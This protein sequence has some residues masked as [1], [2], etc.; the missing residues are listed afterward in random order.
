MR[1]CYLGVMVLD[2]MAGSYYLAKQRMEG[3]AW[4][5]LSQSV[6]I[7]KWILICLN[8]EYLNCLAY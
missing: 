3:D 1:V 8:M 4:S 2:V 7:S 5:A 6:S